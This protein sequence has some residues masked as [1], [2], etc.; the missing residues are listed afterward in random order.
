MNKIINTRSLIYLSVFFTPLYL[1]RFK[2]FSIPTNVL[3]VL[4]FITF[5]SF[6]LE[7]GKNGVID[8]YKQYKK[9]ILAILFILIGLIIST[10]I[11]QDYLGGFG[12]IKGWFV[13]PL[14]LA[15]AIVNVVKN[16]K[17]VENIIKIFYFS[18]FIVSVIGLI[19]FFRNNLTYDIRLKAFYLSPNHLAM[20]LAPA[21]I[22]GILNIKYQAL[23]II[24]KKLKIKNQ[25]SLVTNYP[26]IAGPRLGDG[27]LLV[28]VFTFITILI[29]L[30]LT[31]SYA[32]WTAIIL[33]FAILTLIKRGKLLATSYWLLVTLLILLLIAFTQTNS[34]KFQDLIN[35]DERSSFTS[36]IMIWQSSLKILGDN[37]IF[38]IGP[39]NFQ[40]KYLEYQKNFSPYLEWAVPQPHNLYLAFWLQSGVLGLA[41]FLFLITTWIKKLIMAA[42][43][44]KN[45]I[46][47]STSAVLLGIV[48]YILI[49]GLV[50]TPYWKNDLATIF[51]I[52]IALGTV[53]QN[54]K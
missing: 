24:N 41:G 11:N 9:Y 47:A 15:F 22:I 21:V 19:Y 33:S 38:G 23:S 51:W 35:L 27:K 36:R 26:A 29:S 39:G 53:I 40:N 42:R 12:I 44:Q 4:I 20:F 37:F 31:S 25:K 8:F 14:L 54:R 46:N 10:L 3:E 32:A 52:I 13:V 43:K 28:T 45:G 6:V 5:I 16:E 7:N 48:F 1:I 30:Y 34:T 17:S 50:D 2:I 18:V 49:H